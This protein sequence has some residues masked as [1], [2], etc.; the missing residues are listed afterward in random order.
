[1]G[2]GGN[3]GA[4]AVD[5]LNDAATGAV[6]TTVVGPADGGGTLVQWSDG[7]QRIHRGDQILDVPDQ[8]ATPS[9]AN[10]AGADSVLSPAGQA[11]AGVGGELATLGAKS[12]YAPLAAAPL[13]I[14]KGVE[15]GAPYALRGVAG[16]LRAAGAP[17]TADALHAAGDAIDPANGPNAQGQ[18]V[19]AASAEAAGIKPG[20]VGAGGG[21]GGGSGSGPVNDSGVS[22]PAPA[23]AP[24]GVKLPGAKDFSKDANAG[25]DEQKAALAAG[26]GVEG[27]A[28]SGKAAAERSSAAQEAQAAAQ[29]AEQR[30]AVQEAYKAHAAQLEQAQAELDKQKEDPNR[31]WNSWGTGQRVAATLSQVLGGF[32]EALTGHNASPINKMIEQDIEAQRQNYMRGQQGLAAKRTAY[33]QLREQGLS[34]ADSQ[35]VLKRN[36]IDAARRSAVA[37]VDEK[38]APEI[39]KRRAEA[40]VGKLDQ[41]KAETDAKLQQEAATTAHMRAENA[42]IQRQLATPPG[43]QNGAVTMGGVTQ[44]LPAN[45]KPEQVEKLR[46]VSTAHQ[47]VSD[48][49]RAL[50][51]LAQ[52]DPMALRAAAGNPERMRQLGVDDILLNY[53]KAQGS[54]TATPEPVIERFNEA[55][56]VGKLSGA[57]GFSALLDDL[58]KGADTGADASFG[59]YGLHGPGKI[60]QYND[61]RLAQAGVRPGLAGAK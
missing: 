43:F 61:A 10:S 52:T 1:M 8:P 7:K 2:A 25:I 38:T 14:G 13:A 26:A 54:T 21:P 50:K 39:V 32:G 40:L 11:V 47:V 4:N 55:L 36:Q 23:V 3:I 41:D 30:Q 12:M 34:D 17:Q 35:L 18:R 58:Q 37:M 60:R 56:K 9:G 48:R 5:M 46:E 27:Q 24:A 31:L 22:Q 19:G 16:A 45:L 29:A 42:I 49:I 44:P 6:P 57:D 28:A 15:A 51:Q 59:F 53:G 33:A 20:V